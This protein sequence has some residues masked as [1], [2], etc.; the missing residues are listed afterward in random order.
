MIVRQAP[1]LYRAVTITLQTQD[2]FDKLIACL[3]AVSQNCINHTPQ[4][5]R[6]ALDMSNTILDAL[7]DEEH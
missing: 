3:A 7:E 6:A 5:I 2:E 4:L 1:A